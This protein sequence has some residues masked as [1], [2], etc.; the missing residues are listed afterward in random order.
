MGGAPATVSSSM[1]VRPTIMG[2]M[3]TPG[4]T[5]AEKLSTS[6]PPSMRTAP[7]S[8]ILEKPGVAPVVS[9]STT[10]KATSARSRRRAR[11]AVSPTCTS[12]S[13][14]KRSSLSTMSA[15]SLRMSSGGQ[16]ATGKR[17]G[18]TSR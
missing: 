5:R 7:I 2:G 18:H 16:L 13:Q 10:V 12:L 9:R 15:T 11:Q 1:P 8:V 6:R 3:G 4:F 14:A 17:R